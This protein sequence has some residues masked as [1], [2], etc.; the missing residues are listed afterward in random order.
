[1]GVV[2][3]DAINIFFVCA[4]LSF[5]F[6]HLP[7]FKMAKSSAREDSGGPASFNIQKKKFQHVL[8]AT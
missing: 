2:A 8:L 3:D 7:H 6:P 5:S 1:M 4:S